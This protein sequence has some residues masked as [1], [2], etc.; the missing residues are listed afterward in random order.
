MRAGSRRVARVGIE[1]SA[2]SLPSELIADDIL[3]DCLADVHRW[4]SIP[5][6]IMLQHGKQNTLAV[7]SDYPLH[8]VIV[9][10]GCV[11]ARLCF[12]PTWSEWDVPCSLRTSLSPT[13]PASG[14]YHCP[15]PPFETSLSTLA[16]SLFHFSIFR[17][18]ERSLQP[19]F[20]P[21]E[22][23]MSPSLCQAHTAVPSTVVSAEMHLP[24]SRSNRL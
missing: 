21:Y 3:W 20:L 6:P 1:T 13:F 5:V 2:S 22:Y 7:P 4:W 12:F 24:N 8:P 9:D 10:Y 14:L 15:W 16:L 18:L 17:Q 19:S 23:L 11:V